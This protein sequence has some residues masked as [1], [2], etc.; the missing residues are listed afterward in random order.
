MLKDLN[1]TS[2]AFK[3]PQAMANWWQGPRHVILKV[4]L[5]AGRAVALLKE[6]G[7]HFF[8]CSSTFLSLTEQHSYVSHPKFKAEERFLF[9][10]SGHD[11]LSF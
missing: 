5:H 9:I 11:K 4:A 6:N 3:S 2:S 8:I 7:M 10:Y 1:N